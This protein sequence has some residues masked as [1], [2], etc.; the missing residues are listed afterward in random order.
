[1]TTV[2]SQPAEDNS[3]SKPQATTDGK[4][5]AV[6]DS[7]GTTAASSLK[8]SRPSTSEGGGTGV[9][10]VENALS[11]DEESKFAHILDVAYLEQKLNVI[12]RNGLSKEDAAYRLERDGASQYPLDRLFVNLCS[13]LI[14]RN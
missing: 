2:H 14:P 4:Q 12:V 10:G 11:W 5:K 3:R 13:V 8:Q 1:M 9:V 7:A 6:F